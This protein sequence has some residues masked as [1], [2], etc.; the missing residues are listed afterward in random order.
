[1]I[2]SRQQ[3]HAAAAA[4]LNR[5]SP[6]FLLSPFVLAELDHFLITRVSVAQ[7]LTLLED[8]ARGVYR[9]EAFSA[10]DVAHARAIVER[11]RDLNIGLVDASTVV[12]AGRHDVRD[13]LTLD[14]R[15]FSTLRTP[16]GQRFRILPAHAA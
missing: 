15:H 8:V 5:S 13:V 3:S 4:T 9:L 6:P 14:R 1:M 7:E 16:S 12:L 10:V 2:D 11:Y